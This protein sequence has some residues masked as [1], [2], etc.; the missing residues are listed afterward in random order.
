MKQFWITFFGSI[1]GVVV[2]SVLAVI[3]AAF[4]IVGMLASAVS[5]STSPTTLPGSSTVLELDLRA[6]RLDSPSRSPFAFSE[7][8]SVVEIVQTLEQAEFDPAVHGLFI[9]ANE[10]GLSPGMAEEIRDAIADFRASGK[11]VITHAQGFEGTSV[12]AYL[13]VAGSDEI[14]LQDTAS[15]TPAGLASEVLFLGGMFEQF[16]AEPQFEQ[17]FEFKNAANVYTQTGFTDAHREATLSYMN[18]IFDTA[19]A[20]IAND[21]DITPEALRST[22]ETA[23][24]SAEDALERGLIDHLGHV[25]DAREAALARS[26]SGSQLLAIEAYHSLLNPSSRGPAIA[27]IE[28][29]GAIVTGTA[30]ASPLG[31]GG[32]IGSDAMSEAILDAANDTSI[33]AILIRVDS[34]GGS[35]IASDQVWNAIGR[36]REAGK[37][38]IISMAS[39]AASGGY[40]LAAPADYILAHATTLTGSIGVLG[41]KVALEGTFEMAGLHSESVHVGGDYATA[42]SGQQSWT[43]AQRAAFRAQMADTYDDFTRRV[44]DGRD[45]PLERV[46][47]IARGRVWTGAQAL[48]L[49]LVDEI[50]G[51]R[52][53]V[54]AT[55]HLAGL[56]PEDDV[57]LVRFPRQQTPIEAFSALFGMSAETAETAIRVNAVLDLPE[58]RAALEARSQIGSGQIQLRSTAPQPD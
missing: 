56:A 57:R 48:D 55:K 4:L 30:S 18:S 7:P 53:A 39:V 41:G 42:F 34:P 40:Y 51:F 21:R 14:W 2:G 16:N 5:G 26:G 44:A 38:V 12:T 13:A 11:F 58:V 19:I 46:L 52:D 25:I 33:R 3:L 15:F 6:E 32:G 47:E 31:G 49:G 24:H 23:P 35:A 29:Q 22:F 50:G 28:G 37:P 36:A 10:F 17:F 9:R 45:L 8:L 1:F 27:L 20:D 54:D 43:E